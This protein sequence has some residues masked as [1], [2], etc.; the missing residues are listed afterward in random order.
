MGVYFSIKASPEVLN[1]APEIDEIRIVLVFVNYVG[2]DKVVPGE[3]RM[4]SVIN[5]FV[6][7]S[8]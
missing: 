5:M 2:Q 1:L 3:W 6:D 8:I 4:S 7:I